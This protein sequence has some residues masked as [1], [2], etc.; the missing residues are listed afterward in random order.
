MAIERRE[1][2]VT[3]DPNRDVE[4]FMKRL[5]VEAA[6]EEDT[7][8]VILSDAEQDLQSFIRCFLNL[9]PDPKDD[10]IHALGT[11]VGMDYER[12]EETI[13]SMLSDRLDDDDEMNAS[14]LAEE[15]ASIILKPMT[16]DEQLANDGEPDPRK[17]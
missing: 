15:G 13:Y 3:E 12:L 16:V 10:Q 1:A 7:Q 11:A 9:V 14:L 6:M 5:K 8:E 2:H 4:S 17:N